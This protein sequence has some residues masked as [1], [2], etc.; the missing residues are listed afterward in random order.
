MGAFGLSRCT[1]SVKNAGIL[2]GVHYDLGQYGE[3]GLIAR[4][5]FVSAGIRPICDVR[6]KGLAGA[7][8]DDAAIGQFGALG[9]EA[10]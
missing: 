5:I 3:P 9:E 4:D 10:G 1:G 7:N 8:G 6:G 2:V